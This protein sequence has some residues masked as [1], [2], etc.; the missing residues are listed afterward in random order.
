M[1]CFVSLLS[2]SMCCC[3]VSVFCVCCCFD[4]FDCYDYIYNNDTLI[5]VL[6]WFVCDL[7]ILF[8]YV[9][10]GVH[11]L[12]WLWCGL[13]MSSCNLFGVGLL[14]CWFVYVCLCFDD[15]CVVLWCVQWFCFVLWF[16]LIDV[17]VVLF[18]CVCVCMLLLLLALCSVC[19]WF[20]FYNVL[21]DL[22][23]D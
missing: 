15:V 4:V 10:L 13:P 5:H 23:G 12:C 2:V 20:C 22:W 9:N 19:V 14:W 8:W 16:V 21:T 6:V 3:A 7:D 1:F 11:L 17:C 18:N